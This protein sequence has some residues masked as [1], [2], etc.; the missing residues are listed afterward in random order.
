MED[1]FKKLERENQNSVDNLVK[2]MKDSK[3]V[4][5]TKV[6]EEK[7]RQLF[8]DVKDAS[9]V[10]LAKFQEAIGKLA[11]EQKKSIEDFSKTLAAE[12]PKFLEAAMAA[13]TAAA[14]A[15]A[16]TFKEALSKK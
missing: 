14:A 2:W 6:T 10:E 7:A 5:G 3:I 16:S 4:D 13:A 1:A 8:D 11:S 15:A 9:N 12:A